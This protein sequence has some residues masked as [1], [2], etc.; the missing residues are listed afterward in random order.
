MTA[1]EF[2]RVVEW[3]RLHGYT[4]T[5]IIEFLEFVEGSRKTTDKPET[6]K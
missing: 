6:E 3:L 4:D 1:K 5:D 2:L